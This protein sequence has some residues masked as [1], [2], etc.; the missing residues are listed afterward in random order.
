ML[1]RIFAVRQKMARFIL[2]LLIF[3]LA[4]YGAVILV[5]IFLCNPPS[6]YWTPNRDNC[7]DTRALFLVDSFVSLITDGAIIILPIVLTWPLHLSIAQKVK[8][9][10]IL[11]AGGIATVSN[12]YRLCLIFTSGPSTDP[13]TFTT[14]LE[15][16]G[17]VSHIILDCSSEVSDMA[18]KTVLLRSPLVL[19]VP[20]YLLLISGLLE[21]GNFP[22]RYL[23]YRTSVTRT[24]DDYSH[25]PYSLATK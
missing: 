14:R 10:A 8:V 11:G 21:C 6:A 24:N 9:V 15:F 25:A 12:I 17:Y 2:G 22:L 4:Y 3:I 1:L 7:V 5:R 16:S 18:V 23:E 20:V 19:F 13:T